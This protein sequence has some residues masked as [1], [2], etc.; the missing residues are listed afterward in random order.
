MVC[1]DTDIIIDFLRKD[2]NTIKKFSEFKENNIELKTTAVN[3]FELFKGALRS[4]QEDASE[5][6]SGLLT[7]LK[8]LNF[9]FES[10]KKAAEI[11]EE[12]RIKGEA[13]DPS[14]LMIASIVIANNETLMTRNTK[15]FEK[16]PDLKI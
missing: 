11:I 7:N 4:K 13:I 16:I 5:S 15:H 2:K 3:T 1:L 9:D 8:I 10:S 12:L 14:D 6:L